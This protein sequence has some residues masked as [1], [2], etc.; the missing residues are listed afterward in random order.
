MEVS[1]SAD[2]SSSIHADFE[3]ILYEGTIKIMI[4]KFSKDHRVDLG[5]SDPVAQG[6]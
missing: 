5:T 3:P 6:V 2:W 1:K 4:A